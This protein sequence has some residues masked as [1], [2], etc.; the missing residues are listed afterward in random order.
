VGAE[1][2]I[3]RPVVGAEREIVRPPFI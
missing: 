1:R 2:E 3:V